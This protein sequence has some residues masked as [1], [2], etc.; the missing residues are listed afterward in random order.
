MRGSQESCA[1]SRTHPVGRKA[2]SGPTRVLAG[3]RKR[4]RLFIYLKFE[5][6]YF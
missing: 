5:D 6:V 1:V 3:M 4:Y 2:V